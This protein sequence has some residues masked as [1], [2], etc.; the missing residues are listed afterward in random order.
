MSI[1]FGVKTVFYSEPKQQTAKESAVSYYTCI[2]KYCQFVYPASA[3]VWYFPITVHVPLFR[4]V[5]SRRMRGNTEG[6]ILSYALTASLIPSQKV[7]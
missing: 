1:L 6:I 4:E 3:V 5:F 2:E 7:G